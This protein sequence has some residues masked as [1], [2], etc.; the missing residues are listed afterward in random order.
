MSLCQRKLGDGIVRTWTIPEKR[1]EKEEE[2]EEKGE[3]EEKEL[4][5]RREK[6]NCVRDWR[7]G[8]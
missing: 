3:E 7:E 5:K 2:E 4:K 6:E 8:G 1:E